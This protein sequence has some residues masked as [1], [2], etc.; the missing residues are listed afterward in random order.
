[1]NRELFLVSIGLV[2]MTIHSVDESMTF[3][4][5]S[6]PAWMAQT[7]IIVVLVALSAVHPRLGSW[8]L[9]PAAL[10]LLLGTFVVRTGW[11]AH[12][13]P[14]LE[15]GTDATDATGVLFL[16]G[17]VLLITAGVLLVKHT[18]PVGRRGMSRRPMGS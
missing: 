8:R 15:R 12:V 11:E 16:C 5:P 7:A 4:A 2:L 17:G 1:M 18:I 13:Q 10:V 3:G 9:A 14:L 6:G